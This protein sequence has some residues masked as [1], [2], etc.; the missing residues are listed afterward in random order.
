MRTLYAPT[1]HA[2]VQAV[3]IDAV[4]NESAASASSCGS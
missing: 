2:T 1:R 4:G 3:A